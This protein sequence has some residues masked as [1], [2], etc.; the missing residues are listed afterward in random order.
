MHVNVNMTCLYC[1]TIFTNIPRYNYVDP[2]FAYTNSEALEKKAHKDRYA[3]YIK[4]SRNMQK[5][6]KR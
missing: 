2:D 6:T 3:E 5:Q 4:T 1:R